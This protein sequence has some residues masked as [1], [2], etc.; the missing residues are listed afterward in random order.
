MN[1]R[2]SRDC[3]EDCEFTPAEEVVN[4]FQGLK[5][6][7]SAFRVSGSKE[8]VQLHYQ[9]GTE[10]RPVKDKVGGW[11]QTRGHWYISKMIADETNPILRQ[12]LF[13]WKTEA[14][15][16]WQLTGSSA[17]EAQ[18]FTRVV[19]ELRIRSDG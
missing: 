11:N 17:R 18:E 1:G 9:T 4:V 12:S 19:E 15:H 7:D 2:N 3:L 14:T 5:R 6:L 13:E 8:R 16:H 10:L